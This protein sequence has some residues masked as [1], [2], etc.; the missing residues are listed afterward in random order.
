MIVYQGETEQSSIAKI[1]MKYLYSI[2]KI[3]EADFQSDCLTALRNKRIR[4]VYVL[5]QCIQGGD[6]Y[7]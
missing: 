4:E 1:N 6:N 2:V 3:V 5:K 7:V